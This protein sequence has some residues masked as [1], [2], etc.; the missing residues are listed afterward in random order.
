[1]SKWL[2]NAIVIF[3]AICVIVLVIFCIELFIL[4]RDSDDEGNTGPTISQP[5][6][7]GGEGS[8]GQ[9]ASPD[10]Q[11]AKGD[12]QPGNGTND[13]PT[14][15]PPSPTGKR[16]DL[17]MPGDRNL[18]LYA[19]DGKF[20]YSEL[21]LS[22]LF[23]YMGNEA[24]TLEVCYVHL[25]LGVDARAKECLDGYVGSGKTSVGETGQIG[26][27]DIVGQFVSGEIDG[28]KYEAW[29]YRFTEAG[30]D[31]MGVEFVLHY[32]VDGQREALYTIIDSMSLIPA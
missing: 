15:P 20:I 13:Q 29:I 28:E 8:D 25:P 27:S 30:I 24:V 10:K 6:V 32:R 3:S 12:D 17:P 26:R 7:G 5:A 22:W 11:P 21:E 2:K 31:D 16:R 18:V 4:N 14:Q 19:D 1:M 9:K 23:E